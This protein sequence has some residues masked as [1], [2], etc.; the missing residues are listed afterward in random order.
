LSKRSTICRQAELDYVISFRADEGKRCSFSHWC[1]GQ[2]PRAKAGGSQSYTSVNLGGS[3][4]IQALQNSLCS[5]LH[6]GLPLQRE[7]K[8]Y[9]IYSLVDFHSSQQPHCPVFQDCYGL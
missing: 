2:W 5:S 4:I 7:G 6:C 3:R 9:R 8:K 1:Q